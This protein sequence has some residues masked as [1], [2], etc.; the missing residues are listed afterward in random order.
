ME[1]IAELEHEVSVLESQ[2][3]VARRAV[4]VITPFLASW[5][6]L[7]RAVKAFRD[8]P[9]ETDTAD[10]DALFE[11]LKRS[12]KRSLAI[13]SAQVLRDARTHFWGRVLTLEALDSYADAIERGETPK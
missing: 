12:P 8:G 2:L 7:A 3:A 9:I 6:E 11:L 10:R 13:V 5:A 1:R 4:R